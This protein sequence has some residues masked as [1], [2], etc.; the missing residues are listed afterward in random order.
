MISTGLGHIALTVDLMKH[1]TTV[2]TGVTVLLGAFHEKFAAGTHLRWAIA[3]A[4]I[5]LLITIVY[6]LKAT[7]LPAITSPQA[8]TSPDELFCPL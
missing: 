1:L 4:V 7:G 3:I 5:S 8:I 6:A 2:A